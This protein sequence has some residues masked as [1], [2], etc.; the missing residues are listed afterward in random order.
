MGQ[1]EEPGEPGFGAALTGP[2]GTLQRLE[3]STRCVDRLRETAAL[4]AVTRQDARL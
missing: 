1:R 4:Q 2:W 3:V